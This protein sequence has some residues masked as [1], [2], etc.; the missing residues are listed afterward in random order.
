M[1][2]GLCAYAESDELVLRRPTF[3]L[4]S[5]Y[6]IRARTAD[7]VLDDIGY[8]WSNCNGNDEAEEADVEL[9]C[10]WPSDE[11]P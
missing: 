7:G 9:G 1:L 11:T 4:A 10:R 8:E 5:V 3:G 2:V 6:Q